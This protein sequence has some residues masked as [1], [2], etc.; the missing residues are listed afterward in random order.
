MENKLDDILHCDDK[1]KTTLHCDDKEKLRRKLVLLQREYHRTVQRLKRAEHSEAVRSHVR[2]R[3][4]EQNLHTQSGPG[5]ISGTCPTPS[6][7]CLTPDTRTRT[8]PGSSQGHEQAGGPDDSDNSRK[9]Q[10]IRFVLPSDVACPP[11]PDPGHG[12]DPSGGHKASPALR[13]RSRRSRLRWERRRRS[14]EAGGSTDNSEEGV[15]GEV[16]KEKEKTE[17]M[18]VVSESEELH[19]GSESPSLLLS[20]WN[21]HGH[22]GVEEVEGTE[23]RSQEQRER[24]TELRDEE[25]KESESPSLLLPCW[26]PAIETEGGRQDS[27]DGIGEETGGGEEDETT[28]ERQ[29]CAEL[30]EV[31]RSEDEQN[32]GE[33]MENGKSDRGEKNE[34]LDKVAA[35][36]DEEGAGLLDSCTLVEG[37]LFPVEYYVRTTRRMTISQSQPDMQAIILSQLTG[38]RRSRGRG[39]G[40]GRVCNRSAHQDRH[41]D[42]NQQPHQHTQT[43]FSSSHTSDHLTSNSQSSSDISQI[44]AS[45]TN[46]G[47]FSSTTACTTRSVRG[48]RKS[49]GRGRG[50][51]P[52]SRCSFSLDTIHPSLGQTTDNPQPTSTTTSLS[53]SLSGTDG[54]ERCLSLEDPGAAPHPPQPPSVHTAATQPSSGVDRLESSPASGSLENVYPIF[55]KKCSGTKKPPQMNKMSWQSL[56]LPS[57]PSP[58][59]TLLPLPSLA[60][61]PLV[62]NL[63]SFDFQQ[64]FHLPDDQF[65]SLKLHK[66]RQVTTAVEHFTPPSYNT[67]SSRHINALYSGSSSSEQVAPLSLPLSLTPSIPNS[68]HLPEQTQVPIQSEGLSTVLNTLQLADNLTDKPSTE[69]PSTRDTS[70]HP[71]DQQPENLHSEHQSDTSSESMSLS[72]TDCQS[73]EQDTINAC[74]HDQSS[75]S[76]VTHKQIGHHF[77]QQPDKHCPALPADHFGGKMKDLVMRSDEISTVGQ[78]SIMSTEKQTDGPGVVH[79]LEEQ[80]STNQT[81]DKPVEKTLFTSPR[82]MPEDC[83]NNCSTTQICKD[84]DTPGECSSGCPNVE[85]LDKESSKCLMVDRFE[86][87]SKLPTDRLVANPAQ[88]S[89]HPPARSQLLISP[90]VAS[91]PCPFLNPHLLS[92][93]ALTSSPP[94]PSLG[95]TPHPVAAALPLTLSHSGPA[96]TQPPPHSPSTLSP[97]TSFIRLPSTPSPVPCSRHIQVSSDPPAAARQCQSVV[98]GPCQP[99]P[100]FQMQGTGEQ[101]SCGIESEDGNGQVEQTKEM[102]E[103]HIMRC[104]HVLK[105]PAGGCLV[106]ACCLPGP[107]GSLYVAAAG[108]WA[109]CVWD[110]TAA[111]DWSLMHTWTF[112]EPVISVFPVPDAVGLMCVTLGQLEIREV[113]MLSCSS[114]LQVLLCEGLVQA[115]V[116]VARSRVVSSSHSATSSTLQLFTLSEDSSA[117]ISQPLTSPG[118]CVEALAAVDGL[119]D[120]LIGSAEGGHLFIWNLRTGQLLQRI[121]LREGLSYTACLRG[122]TH[123]G[124][125]LVLLQHQLLSSLEEEEKEAKKTKEQM[126]SKEEQEEERKRTALLS[127]VAVNPLNGR[128]A[129]ATHICTPKTWSGRLCEADVLGSRVVGL[130]QSGC[131]FVW[132]LVGRRG[133]RLVWTPETE[134]WQLARWGGQDTLITG[135]HNGDLTLHRYTCVRD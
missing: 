12:L 115:V 121:I 44:P 48:R 23:R 75:T 126:F 14:A 129:L 58:R 57:S 123:G 104:T 87:N 28:G 86:P 33:K 24:K 17:E 49:R 95:E 10:V 13:L 70:E 103:E 4:T 42:T 40:R 111:S 38:G 94:L 26:S 79:H 11:T 106:D 85:S 105:A 66:L 113:R 8:T 63:A 107:S 80:R 99:E 76:S 88:C 114:R 131:V 90:T 78:S 27:T 60:P 116:G 3:I 34:G 15:E 16:E 97:S 89:P 46:S 98:P 43:N 64:D 120:A 122:Y 118:V 67:R 72:A 31:N 1:L 37:L 20:H 112:D 83:S 93:A 54:P 81:E 102:A 21:S 5:L 35:E 133:S 39:R 52:S 135:H 101:A 134:G 50:K 96:L 127:L 62:N 77:T 7:S 55:Q 30:C 124:V 130:S 69:D 132:E 2:S 68:P 100:C 125:L 110:H 25:S 53:P 74:T 84:T 108:K 9:N 32:A 59:T 82:E 91:P 73:K 22:S 36:R 128:S 6:S 109:V 71:G 18:T 41:T 117:P 29:P 45:Q 92:S 61:G 51:A 56:L 19:A 47:V 119:S 65:A